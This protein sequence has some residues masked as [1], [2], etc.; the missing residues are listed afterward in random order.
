MS[1]I[2]LSIFV[3][4]LLY[5]IIIF[6]SRSTLSQTTEQEYMIEFL[7]YLNIEQWP[8]L[9]LASLPNVFC[10]PSLLGRTVFTAS[11]RLAV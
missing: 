2:V 10:M 9:R 3:L 11:R 7:T 5:S 4:F 8:W 6:I 1:P